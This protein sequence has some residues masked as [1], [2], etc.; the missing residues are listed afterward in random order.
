MI[1]TRNHL[2]WL[3]I[4]AACWWL[5]GIG[6][7]QQGDAQATQRDESQRPDASGRLPETLRKLITRKPNDDS[8]KAAFREVIGPAADATVRIL[9]HGKDA[10]LGTIVD[11]QGYIVT[12]ASLLD[13][14]IVCRFKGG[15][16]LVATL[17]GVREDHDL[18]LLKTDAEDLTPVPWRP[19]HAPPAGSWIASVGPEDIPLA[20]GVVSAE[21]RRIGDLGCRR[22]ET[23]FLGVTLEEA[24]PGP[25]IT[26]I[27]DDTAA[28][29]AGLKVDD[30][31]VRIDEK[32][33]RTIQQMI[34]AIGAE[35]PG[36]TITLAVRRG[37]EDLELPATL[38]KAK[39]DHHCQSGTD[40]WGGGPFS[41]RRGRFPLAMPH[42]TAIHPHDCGGPIVDTDGRVAGINIAR[43]LRVTS[44]AIPAE[45]VRRVV[46]EMKN[47]HLAG[48]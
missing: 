19:G 6:V 35:P 17:V 43:A 31:I 44:F 41:K 47:A 33:V 3:A 15:R 28:E 25:R 20:V 42:D 45:V 22:L 21:P 9:A 12:K 37:Q 29:E 30:L 18:A 5:Y 40:H 39:T 38:D 36:K 8:I 24:D 1:K 10:A 4:V 16:E 48:N 11:R 26:N 13:G 2:V 14:R 7:P 27:H 34:A 46:A 32:A 23:G